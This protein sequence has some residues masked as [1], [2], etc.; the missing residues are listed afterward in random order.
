[1]A[2]GC[3]PGSHRTSSCQLSLAAAQQQQ[4]CC[5]STLQLLLL[6]PSCPAASAANSGSSS[7]SMQSSTTANLDARLTA[8]AK[9]EIAV[10]LIQC[11]GCA[12]YSCEGTDSPVVPAAALGSHVLAVMQLY[13]ATVRQSHLV[14]RSK[15]AQMML[16]PSG[17]GDCLDRFCCSTAAVP[18]AFLD[19]AGSAAAAQAA[20]I[21][22]EHAK[23][24]LA[25][26]CCSALKVATAVAAVS[27]M[28]SGCLS[29][30]ACCFTLQE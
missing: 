14:P 28:C 1:V 6:L 20:G 26:L 30:D 4:C 13:E 21:D 19:V 16:S 24:Q 8:G 23:V 5:C 29:A 10:C 22:A 15:Q 9:F 12:A 17:L 18:G 2:L 11:A 7:S 3:P 25:S 27:V